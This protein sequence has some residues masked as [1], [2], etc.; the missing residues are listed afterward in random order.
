MVFLF[1][2]FGRWPQPLK[3]GV[4]ERLFYDG[5]CGL[6]HHSVLFALNREPTPLSDDEPPPFRFA[7][8]GGYTFEELA[9]SEDNPF[10]P[11]DELP[12]SIVV[13]TA[14]N[15]V[16]TRSTAALYV[17]R[18]LGGIWRILATPALIVPRPLRDLVYS[19]IASLRHRL[20]K[21][22][23]NACPIVPRDLRSR[24]EP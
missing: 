5:S 4:Q 18:R 24:F 22:P 20:F 1:F 17:A 23:E 12:D 11:L 9:E 14:D 19:A 3:R 8:L 15:E 13:V 10:P 16:L 6:C 7:P 21:S 2:I